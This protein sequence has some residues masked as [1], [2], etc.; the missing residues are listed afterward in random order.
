MKGS[1]D[2]SEFKKEDRYLV[3]KRK[4]LDKHLS[5]EGR[6]ALYSISEGLAS[7]LKEQEGK[8]LNCV[9]VEQDW[10]MF[11]HVWEEIQRFCEGKKLRREELEE[12]EKV[13]LARIGELELKLADAMMDAAPEHEAVA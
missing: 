7:R 3:F 8:E 2:M 1:K 6:S 12:N 10:P 13:L 11:A 9:V 4:D 5:K